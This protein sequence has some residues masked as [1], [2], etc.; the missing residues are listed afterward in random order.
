MYGFMLN[1]SF[2]GADYMKFAV[3]IRNAGL[4]PMKFPNCADIECHL[5]DGKDRLHSEESV[6]YTEPF[7]NSNEASLRNFCEFITNI[8]TE[9][10]PSI[11]VK[12]DISS[13][14]LFY[15]TSRAVLF[16][17]NKSMDPIDYMD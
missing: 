15:N 3:I 1:I 6:Q 7:F 10:T 2:G 12:V 4:N 16:I 11:D 13:V 14:V 9:D 8:K 5:Y 17:R